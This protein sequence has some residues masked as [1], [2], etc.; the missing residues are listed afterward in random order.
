[1]ATPAFWVSFF[2]WKNRN[3]RNCALEYLHLRVQNSKQ[4]GFKI[5]ASNPLIQA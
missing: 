5:L 1:L 2:L 4:N 3:F